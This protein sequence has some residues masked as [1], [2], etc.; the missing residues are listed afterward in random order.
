MEFGR[1]IELPP[2]AGNVDGLPFEP[3]DEW[4]A[5]AEGDQQIAAMRRWF[6]D[7][8]EDPANETPWDGEDKTYV[9]IWGGPYDPNDEIQ[10]RFGGIV[11]YETMHELIQELWRDVGDEWAPIEHEGVDYERHLQ[12]TVY[13]RYDPARFLDERL[14]QIDAVLGA[15]SEAG[16]VRQLVHQMAHSSLIAALEAYLSDTMSFWATSNEEILRRVVATNKD[17]QAMRLSVAE[18]FQRL[19]GLK[20]EIKSYFDGFMWH[21][22]DKVKPMMAS[23]LGIEVPDIGGLVQEVLV[24]HDIVHR[25]GR[26]VDG[27]LVDLSAEDVLRVRDL[28]QGFADQVEEQLKR[29]FPEGPAPALKF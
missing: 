21:R 15:V 29:R 28:V 22:L 2:G 16:E 20:D 19:D 13:D 14:D 24:R 3:N 11:P 4:L 7:R 26:G 23:G 10:E 5:S 9:F 27:T 18:L 17:F 1:A 25:A 6:L 12:R 8:Y